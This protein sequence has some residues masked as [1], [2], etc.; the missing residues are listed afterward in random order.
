MNDP[1]QI[2]KT[3]R[4]AAPSSDLDGRL[5][6][7]FAAAAR[8]RQSSR[9]V[10]RIWWITGLAALGSAAALFFVITGWPHRPVRAQPVVFRF[11][12][13]GQ[14]RQLLLGPVTA[15]PLPHFVTHVSAP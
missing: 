14:M 4:L 15:S 10:T 2:L 11:E 3:L 5:D 12:A 6:E 8:S 13:Q 1:E 7:A 9:R